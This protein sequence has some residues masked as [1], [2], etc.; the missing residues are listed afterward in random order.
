[1]KNGPGEL[2]AFQRTVA[3]FVEAHGLDAPAEARV[4]DLVSEVG[5]LAKEVLK[6][7]DYG[8][9]A[10]RE[11]EDWGDELGD[12]LFALICAANGTGV[13]LAIALD[14]TLDK[15]RQRLDL[16]GDAGSGG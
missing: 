11:T 14:K 16:G 15:Y 5:E 1:M 3:G 12:A 2:P 6:G 4:L 10:F 13:N 7:T 8:R 9:E